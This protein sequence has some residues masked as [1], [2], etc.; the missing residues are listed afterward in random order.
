MC[1]VLGIKIKNAGEEDYAL[2]RNLFI[3][4]MIRG[5]HA[6]GVS[7]VKNGEIV[8]IKE[9]IPANEF[10]AKHD[11]K[12]WV[13]ED[14]NLYC[15]GHIRYSTSDLNYNQPFSSADISIVHNGVISQEDPSTWEETY[16][17]KTETANDSELILHCLEIGGDPL[18]KFNPASMA[19]CVLF[20]DKTL[21]GFRNEARPLYY[22]TDSTTTVLTSTENIGIRAGLVGLSK[23]DMYKKYIQTE[24]QYNEFEISP[25]PL[26]NV[27]DLQ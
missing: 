10:I 5:K 19:V 26:K 13:N 2:V 15:I 22:Y 14:G 20:A 1:G 11:V 17:L 21:V 4:S 18:T 3:Q 23:T 12:D 8:T 6:T 16:G 9:P 24:K 25:I 27:E 7:Y